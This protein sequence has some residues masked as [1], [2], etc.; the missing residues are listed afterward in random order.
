M[1][2]NTPNYQIIKK[3]KKMKCEENKIKRKLKSAEVFKCF[4]CK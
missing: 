3:N 1:D 4:G 2:K